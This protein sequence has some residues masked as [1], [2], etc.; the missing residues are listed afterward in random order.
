MCFKAN[1]TSAILA[2]TGIYGEELN[3]MQAA[4]GFI[5]YVVFEG[6]RLSGACKQMGL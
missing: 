6:F 2:Y 1:F 3:E 4:W 5:I